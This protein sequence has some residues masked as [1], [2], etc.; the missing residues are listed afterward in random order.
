MEGAACKV[1]VA[2]PRVALAGDLMT[3]I[4]PN[5]LATHSPQNR[6]SLGNR[7]CRM[8]CRVGK[9]MKNGSQFQAAKVEYHDS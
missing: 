7:T 2:R 9:M 5:V 8:D 4:R 6:C 1:H 3:F